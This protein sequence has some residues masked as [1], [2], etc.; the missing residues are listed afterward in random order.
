MRHN[1]NITE[2]V[3]ICTQCGLQRRTIARPRLDPKSRGGVFPR[4]EH[5]YLINNQWVSPIKGKDP[6]NTRICKSPKQE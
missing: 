5:Q 6:N 1:W 2:D 4:P 3:D